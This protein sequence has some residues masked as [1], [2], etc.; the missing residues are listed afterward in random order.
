MTISK[1][2]G[3]YYCRFQIDGERHHY[4]CTGAK[5]EKEALKLESQYMYKVQQ[6]INGAM[7]RE[8]S[9]SK[10]TLN[11]LLNLYVKY[12]AINNKQREPAEKIKAFKLF[13]GESKKITEI[14]PKQIESFRVWLMD[15]KHLSASTVNRYISCLS[16]AYNLAIDNG[17]V[18]FNPCTRV[19]LLK[20]PKET[21][22]FYTE[23]EEKQLFKGLEAFR[24]DFIPFVT[25]AFQ[26]GLRLS[27]IIYFKWEWVNLKDRII[28]IQPQDNK[29][30]KLIRLYISDK[31]LNVLNQLNKTTD[32]VFINPESGGVYLT[33]DRILRKVCEKINLKY[34]GF[35][36]IRHTVGT[37]LV[38]SGM[39]INVVQAVL[40]HTD[41][42]TTMKYVHL[43]DN[44]I[45]DAISV[46]N[47]YN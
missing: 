13:F 3:K 2:N 44:S 40:A 12:N 39:P 21:I 28:E 23:S 15:E 43:Q 27:N 46:L 45:K 9:L 42:R 20:E 11:Y 33:A 5:T 22:K 16:K 19:K 41:I 25:C 38:K 18:E 35:H 1:R 7:P 6:Q 36:G 14:K 29:G 24:P 4:L 26:T 8:V 32:Y 30:H 47:S 34:I 31:L 10:T 17:L 37:R